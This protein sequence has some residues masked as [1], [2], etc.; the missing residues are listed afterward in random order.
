M[1]DKEIIEV[2]SSWISL[3]KKLITSVSDLKNYKRGQK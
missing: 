2:I 1:N 3:T